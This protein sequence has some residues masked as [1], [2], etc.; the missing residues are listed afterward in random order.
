MS[1]SSIPFDS[2]AQGLRMPWV[3]TGSMVFSLMMYVLLAHLLGAELQG[4]ISLAEEQRILIR[5]VFYIV[6]II[7]LPMTNLLRHVMIRLN[8]TMPGPYSPMRRYLVTVLVSMAMV[9]T[10]GL[11]GLIMFVLGDDFNNLYIFTGMSAL[12]MYLYRPKANEYR[13]IVEALTQ[14]EKSDLSA[15]Y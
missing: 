10:I 15:N 11:F 1:D 3:I 8:Q 7:T 9:E 6:A 13:S 4:T 14:A 2:M 12:G 5:T